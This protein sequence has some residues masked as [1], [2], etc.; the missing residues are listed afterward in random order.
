MVVNKW[1]EVTFEVYTTVI[2]A[3]LYRE[4]GIISKAAAERATY[5]AVKLFFLK[6]TIGVVHKFYWIA[7]PKGVIAVGS[8]YSTTQVIPIIMLTFAAWKFIQMNEKPNK[9]VKK[10]NQENIMADTNCCC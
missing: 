1:V 6:S 3:I 4:M 9:E 5:I 7:K 2:I 8:A 10:V